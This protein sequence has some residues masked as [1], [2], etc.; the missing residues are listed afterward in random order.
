MSIFRKLLLPLVLI[1][2]ILTGLTFAW[3][4]VNGVGVLS[5]QIPGT[6]AKNQPNITCVYFFARKFKNDVTVADSAACKR[7]ITLKDLDAQTH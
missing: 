3:L 1:I 2:L 7:Q 4:Y 5:Q 6:D